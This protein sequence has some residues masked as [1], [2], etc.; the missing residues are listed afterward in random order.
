MAAFTSIA[1]GNYNDGPTT[2][3]TAA[4]TFPG[5]TAAQADTITVAAGHTVTL[6]VTTLAGTVST[7]TVAATGVFLVAANFAATSKFTGGAW[8][9]EGTLRWKNDAAGTYQLCVYQSSTITVKNGGTFEM[10]STADPAIIQILYLSQGSVSNS[11]NLYCEAGGTINIQGYAT[12][13][14]K[15]TSAA[16]ISNG[17]T[18]ITVAD[19]TGWAT[20]DQIILSY[21]QSSLS[22]TITYVSPGVYNLNSASTI[23]YPATISIYN[24]TKNVRLFNNNGAR[25]TRMQAAVGSIVT[26]KN[27]SLIHFQMN[28]MLCRGTYQRLTSYCNFGYTFY[29]NDNRVRASELIG[30]V[31]GA[32]TTNLLSSGDNS[33]LEDCDILNIH[34][35]AN[36]G[37]RL[38]QSCMVKNFYV[39]AGTGLSVSSSGRIYLQNGCINSCSTVGIT[40]ANYEYYYAGNLRF[41]EDEW[42]GTLQNATD[43]SLGYAWGQFDNCKFSASSVEVATPSL[44]G[45]M[46]ILTNYDQ[47][48]GFRKEFQRYGI[49]YSNSAEARSGY[50]LACDPSS[51]TNP[52][53]LLF[54]FPCASGMNPQIKFW[55]KKSGTMGDVGVLLPCNSAGIIEVT[56]N[57]GSVDA[58]GYIT[59]TASW[60]QYTVNLTGNST[61]Y[62]EVEVAIYMFDSSSGILYI[63]DITISGNL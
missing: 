53:K 54:S 6:N 50:C 39:S 10:L 48:E 23:N 16:Q 15:T 21:G 41:G 2:W 12:K 25:Q 17:T 7:V 58:N 47:T 37:M 36:V 51:T 31:Y 20:G 26:L 8:T 55:A 9:I 40:S 63:D 13:T 43:L 19:D 62:G 42:G 29:F 18:Q 52:M 60:A 49:V 61:I 14:Q 32:T 57:S 3:G 27:V 34:A 35:T 24:M 11:T 4:G 46:V 30:V 1:S 45:S 44:D 28:Q 38:L 5:S 33:I 22:R 56:N 59:P